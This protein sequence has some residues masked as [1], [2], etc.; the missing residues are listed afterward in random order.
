MY[1]IAFADVFGDY[2]RLHNDYVFYTW[3][4]TVVS[5]FLNVISPTAS[6]MIVT[7]IATSS[8]YQ[9]NELFPITHHRIACTMPVMGLKTS[10]LCSFCG[11][12]FNGYIIGVMYIHAVRV[13]VSI[14]LT[15]RNS[16]CGGD[17]HKDM[18]KVN[19]Y[20]SSKNRGSSNICTLGSSPYKSIT[21][22]SARTPIIR[23]SKDA[24]IAHIGSIIL[25]K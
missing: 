24:V 15:S 3:S 11:R 4:T 6:K 23:S 7:A 13:N 22:N 21:P 1:V 12:M 5:K 19:R 20:I 25:V 2:Y 16:A 8:E 14:I 18:P 17:K 10:M 9:F